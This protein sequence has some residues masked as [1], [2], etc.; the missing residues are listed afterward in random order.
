MKTFDVIFWGNFLISWQFWR[1]WATTH[2]KPSTRWWPGIFFICLVPAIESPSDLYPQKLVFLH[3]CAAAVISFMTWIRNHLPLPF[4][5]TAPAS[6]VPHCSGVPRRRSET[7][8][9]SESTWAVSG[10]ACCLHV[11]VCVCH[12]VSSL[13]LWPVVILNFYAQNL[14]CRSWDRKQSQSGRVDPFSELPFGFHRW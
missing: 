6:L 8:Y 11:A 2:E 3:S 10:C 7:R 9:K 5:V 1:F 14:R 12:K 4:T 13:L